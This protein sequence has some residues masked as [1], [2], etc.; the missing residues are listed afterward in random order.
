MMNTYFS[1]RE[2][3]KAVIQILNI[4]HAPSA[5]D[6]EMHAW[7]RSSGLPTLVVATKADKIV[8]GQWPKQLK[9]IA[10]GLGLGSWQL[11][12]PYSAETG[13]GVEELHKAVE[14]HMD[15][16]RL[17]EALAD[18]WS[19]VGALNKYIDQTTPWLLA[20]DEAKKNVL[21]SVMYHLAEGLRIIS[22][23]LT[24]FIPDT[25]QRIQD[26]LGVED[27]RTVSW[28]SV[29]SFT[30]NVAG[31]NVK[32][33]APIFPRL[34]I[35]KELE[36]LEEISDNRTLKK[37]KKVPAEAKEPEKQDE[38]KPQQKKPDKKD[39]KPA[40]EITYEEFRRIDLR[41]GVVKQAEAVEGT[42]K[43]IKITV[44]I[45]GE[46]RQIVSGIKQWYKPEELI[47]K[48]IIVV[49]NLKP[50]KLKGIDSY[51]MLLAAESDGVLRLATIDGD[52]NSGAPVM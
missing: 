43:L 51:G 30:R 23:L 42:D 14:E 28:D 48:T 29:K 4:R 5:E 18:I 17:P 20:R 34:D 52:V 47:G 26:I 32:Q 45:G 10:Q 44:D 12:L 24:P 2:S 6:K 41:L 49:A 50:T 40:D 3:L 11:I 7:L 21:A 22:V 19:Y 27:Y 46:T 8:R 1:K 13:E 35:K 38:K 15:A 39:I 25:A 9:V 31:L 37:Q 33:T 36:S 16:L